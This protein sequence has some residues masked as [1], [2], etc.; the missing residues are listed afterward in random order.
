MDLKPLGIVKEIVETAG[1]SI[2]YAYD[3]LVFIA[4]NAYLL[5]FTDKN[6][7]LMIHVNSE[8]D[9][10]AIQ[11]D[12]TRLK[13]EASARNI[14][15]KDGSRYTLSQEGNENIRLEFAKR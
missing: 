11:E 3:D 4:H 10:S 6:S 7:E 9:E 8:A 13:A 2:S 1:M 5:Q 15:F 12:I 14:V